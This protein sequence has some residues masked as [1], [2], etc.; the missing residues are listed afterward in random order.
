MDYFLP[1]AAS[2][3]NF[4]VLYSTYLAVRKTGLDFVLWSDE[5]DR[6]VPESTKYDVETNLFLGTCVFVILTY[7]FLGW[8]T[9]TS[10]TPIIVTSKRSA[11]HLIDR[12]PTIHNEPSPP[13]WCTNPHVQF[14]PWCLQGYIHQY[15]Y[16]IPFQRVEHETPCGQDKSVLDV[17]PSFETTPEVLPIAIILPGLRGHSQDCPGGAVVRRFAATKK[18]RAIVHHR[19]GHV[20]GETLQAGTFHFSGDH[21][22]LSFSIRHI[23]NAYPEHKDAPIFL[24]GISLGS[25]HAVCS[26]AEWDRLRSQNKLDQYG[27]PAPHNIGGIMC[28]SAGFD[29]SRCFRRFPWPY[30]GLLAECVKDH[31]I[32]RNEELLRK[33]HG[34]EVVDRILSIEDIQEFVDEVYPF[35]GLKSTEEFYEKYNP[36]HAMHDFT[37]PCLFLLAQDDPITIPH[38]GLEISP[39]EKYEG[40]SYRQYLERR[41]DVCAIG[42]LPQTGS[43]CTFI[44]GGNFNC[45]EKIYD[46]WM[47]KSWAETACVEFCQAIVDLEYP[48]FIVN[49]DK[50]KRTSLSSDSSSQPQDPEQEGRIFE[51]G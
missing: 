37:T 8:C 12:V 31:F 14:F 1:S 17:Y 50:N 51:R 26:V 15:F 40:C 36:V 28:T 24:V 19:R 7:W 13:I 46:I 23:R 48:E 2:K 45:F 38:N 16:P 10:G 9:K 6:S 25:A 34:D 41:D 4:G 35:A 22:D 27:Y 49:N 29:T 42:V 43:H 20:I 39:Y 3:F 44:D 47:F 33:V 21:E 18:F 30:N 32:R 5:E 11:Q